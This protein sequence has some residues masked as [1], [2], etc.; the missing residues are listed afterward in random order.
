MNLVPKQHHVKK[1]GTSWSLIRSLK[2]VMM[3]GLLLGQWKTFDPK[4][5]K[6]SM[7][8][9]KGLYK[10]SDKLD[11]RFAYMKNRLA[12]GFPESH[13]R[14]TRASRECTCSV[15]GSEPQMT[16]EMRLLALQKKRRLDAVL[17]FNHSALLLWMDNHGYVDFRKC[18]Q[19]RL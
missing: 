13:D 9:K 3:G 8:E 11:T 17:L 1:L 6:Q 16:C 18:L 15:R 2:P 14:P 12:E 19:T 5:V 10:P 4:L 7:S